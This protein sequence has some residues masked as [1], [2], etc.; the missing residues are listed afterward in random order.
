MA[1]GNERDLAMPDPTPADHEQARAI[2]CA[3]IGCDERE[4]HEPECDR[5]TP[6]FA[7]ALADAR[8]DEQVPIHYA[9]PE[10]PRAKWCDSPF[11]LKSTSD[12]EKV[13]CPPCFREAEREQCAQ[14]VEAAGERHADLTGDD[15][16]RRVTSLA[17]TYLRSGYDAAT[18]RR[19]L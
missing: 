19:D 4:P 9:R 8:L 6:P 10:H 3:V 13:T 17:A 1:D 7:Q 16:P 2:V 11:N 14:A 12:H 5:M 18:I 15:V